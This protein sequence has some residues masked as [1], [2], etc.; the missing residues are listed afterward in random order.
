MNSAAQVYIQEG[1]SR[2]QAVAEGGGA[3]IASVQ[4]FVRI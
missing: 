2:A 4:P 1:V 3:Y